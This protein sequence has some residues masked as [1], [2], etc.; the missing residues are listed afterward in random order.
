[1]SKRMIENPNKWSKNKVA[2]CNKGEVCHPLDESSVKYSLKGSIV[3]V[4]WTQFLELG[5][6][7]KI[8]LAKKVFKYL[9]KRQRKFNCI[10]E[11]NMKTDHC[12]IIQ[13]LDDVILHLKT[14]I[15][16]R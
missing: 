10:N 6:N 9:L 8:K 12:S 3:F 5:L 16:K 4:I 1:M 14:K 15:M 7:Q 2:V 11:Y 13:F